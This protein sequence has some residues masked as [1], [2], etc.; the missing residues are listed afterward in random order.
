M[1]VHTI[2]DE[3]KIQEFITKGVGVYTDNTTEKVLQR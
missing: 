1:F 2:N 3:K